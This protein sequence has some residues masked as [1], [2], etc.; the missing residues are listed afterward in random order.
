[1]STI[2]KT[3]GMLL[4]LSGI[5]SIIFPISLTNQF[6]MDMNQ[7]EYTQSALEDIIFGFLF[8]GV[9]NAIGKLDQLLEKQN[10]ELKNA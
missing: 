6:L 10:K 2:L 5:L 3:L 7:Y 1:M 9:G 8:L 4:C